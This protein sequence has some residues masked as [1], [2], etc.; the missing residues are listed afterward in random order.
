[1]AS[2]LK[3]QL[4][5][6]LIN[7][8]VCLF[9]DLF[10]YLIELYALNIKPCYLSSALTEQMFTEHAELALLSMVAMVPAK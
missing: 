4:I 5:N 7:V 6:E 1:M 10:I 8:F 2:C 9:V 3:C